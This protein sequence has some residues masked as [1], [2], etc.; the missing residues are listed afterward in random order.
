MALAWWT[1]NVNAARVH[2]VYNC[3]PRVEASNRSFINVKT[4]KRKLWNSDPLLTTTATRSRPRNV[5]SYEATTTTTYRKCVRVAHASSK[6]WWP[7]DDK[8]RR[9]AVNDDDRPTLRLTAT[10]RPC[11]G[12]V[13]D[14]ADTQHTRRSVPRLF[15]SRPTYIALLCTRWRTC[16]AVLRTFGSAEF[17]NSTLRVVTRHRQIVIAV[18]NRFIAWHPS[19][20]NAYTL[21]T[22]QLYCRL[23]TLAGIFSK[24]ILNDWRFHFHKSLSDSNIAWWHT[25]WGNVCCFRFLMYFW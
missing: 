20:K 15:I 9:P 12:T 19:L 7:Y 3:T 24:Q 22:L 14:G 6:R 25:S 8:R 13:D 11:Y 5:I 10:W 4:V 2:N 16:G 23:A 21:I 1:I 17:W 18:F